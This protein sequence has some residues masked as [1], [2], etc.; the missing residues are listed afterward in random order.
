[1]NLTQ[2]KSFHYSAFYLS[3]SEASNKLSVSQPAVTK[4]V[5]NLEK[6]LDHKLF[7]RTGKKLILTRLGSILYGYSSQIFTL[8]DKAEKEMVLHKEK[9][10][11]I[12]IAGDINYLSLYMSKIYPELIDEFPDVQLEI[13]SIENSNK[14]F[15]SVKDGTVD[16]GIMT[17]NYS[18][19]GVR[20]HLLREDPIYLLA[21][22][23]SAE[24]KSISDIPLLIYQSNSSYSSY[25]EEFT[26]INQ[27]KSS[28]KI[29]FNSLELVRQA[30]LNHAGMAVLS[31]DIIK[32]DLHSGKLVIL[33]TEENNLVVK[34]RAI[35]RTNH[36][37]TNKLE[38]LLALI[39]SN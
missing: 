28:K 2:L 1:M 29:T 14:I 7:I 24:R 11:I 36:P 15:E 12:K 21:S 9:P 25:L 16:F 31:E 39:K 20:Q 8:L 6:D 34:T 10:L 26:R 33:P 19:I 13:H 30:L 23:K 17:G 5:Q 27:L 4:Q 22:S 35:F 32:S 38:K 37:L 18:S 3:F